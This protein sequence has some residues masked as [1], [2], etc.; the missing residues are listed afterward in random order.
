MSSFLAMSIT[1]TGCATTN[2]KTRSTINVRES[3]PANTPSAGNEPQQSDASTEE[4]ITGDE[5]DIADNTDEEEDLISNLDDA[6]FCKDTLY[7]QYLK[8]QYLREHPKAQNP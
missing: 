4:N 3:L 8:D 7:A 6:E 5:S 1:W 2:S